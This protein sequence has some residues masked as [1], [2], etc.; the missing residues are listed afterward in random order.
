VWSLYSA[1][2]PTSDIIGGGLRGGKDALNEDSMGKNLIITGIGGQGN[3]MAATLLA[4]AILDAGWEVTV[5]D[6]YGLTQRGGSVA[7]HVRWNKGDPLPP[8]IPYRSLDILIAF[9]PLEALR[10][11]IQFGRETTRAI[12]NDQPVLPIGVQAGR[13]HYPEVRELY[14][15]IKNLSGETMFTAA[16]KMA[17]E[18]GNVQVLNMVML[19]VLYGCE[20]IPFSAQA[21]E[22]TIQSLIPS[23]LCSLNIEAFRQGLNLSTSA[24]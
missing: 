19:G 14:A 7:S 17:T 13:L 22:N 3:V 16:T 9:E 21:F 10:I 24:H 20:W 11:L 2:P 18:L 1:V 4:S 12:V 6:V 8:L 23:K 5:G 15:A